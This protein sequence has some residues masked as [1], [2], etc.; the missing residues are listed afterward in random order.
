MTPPSW[1][2]RH[3]TAV[4]TPPSWHRRHYNAVITTP[5]WHRRHDTIAITPPSWH[6]RHD[7]AVMTPL[8]SHRRH[9]NAVITPPSYCRHTP[10][11]PPSHLIVV[12]LSSYC[13][14]IT[15]IH[16]NTA[17]T[18]RHT[19]SHRCHIAVTPPHHHTAVIGY[20]TIVILRHTAI[21]HHRGRATTGPTNENFFLFISW[22]R[23]GNVFPSCFY[24]VSMPKN[25]RFH[26]K[27]EWQQK[28]VIF[29]TV[30][31]VFIE[32]RELCNSVKK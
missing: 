29:H 30:L 24:F 10:V 18:R 6:R 19:P 11:I 1:H 2:R 21:G 9:H 13:R 17:I 28:F 20:Q 8:S 3:D 26:I 16:W 4:M 25:V 5:S 27:T 15:F 22:S 31:S 7:T 23:I 32:G 14:H 12:I